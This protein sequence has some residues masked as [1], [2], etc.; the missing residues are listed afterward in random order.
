MVSD[1]YRSGMETA[2]VAEYRRLCASPD[3]RQPLAYLR[4][5][6]AIRSVVEHRDIEPGQALPS[7]REDCAQRPQPMPRACIG[8]SH[9]L[10]PSLGQ[11]RLVVAL[12]RPPS[13]D[14]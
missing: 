10:S 4:L 12:R 11:H 3:T 6:R 5:R 14:A 7:E 1:W 9:Y 2:L 13:S 8:E